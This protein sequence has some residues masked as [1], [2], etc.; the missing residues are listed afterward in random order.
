MWE[1]AMHG[2]AGQR[3]ML[4]QGASA[5]NPIEVSERADVDELQSLYRLT[6][7]LYRARSTDEVFAA[8]LD[9]ITETLGCS[10]ASILLFD[11]D[12]V[13]RFKAARGL[14]ERY[15]TRLEGHT[16]WR[17]G[18]TDPSPIFVEDIDETAEADWVKR[19]IRSEG[20]RSLGFIPLTVD[21]GVVGK[22]MTYYP[23]R[24]TLSQH[25]ADLAVTIARQVGFSVHRARIEAMRR[26][27]EEELRHSEARFRSMSEDAPVM[28]WMSDA[29]GSCLHLNRMLRET[30]GVQED[31]VP[32]FDWRRTM[33]PQD[34]PAIIAAVSD[35]I[36]TRSNL[37]VKG[38]YRRWD[39]A[40]RTFTT[41]ARPNFSAGGQFLGMI[42]VNVD[43]TDQE[44]AAAQRELVF[45][46]L[47]HR[48]KN[49]LALVQAI[50]HQTLKGA[51]AAPLAR[52]FEDRLANLAVAHDLL[53]RTNWENAPLR[54]LL[55]DAL[56]AHDQAL[57][58]ELSGPEVSLAPKQA[59][60]IA[61]AIHELITNAVKYGALSADGGRV[62]LT[63]RVTPERVLDIGWRE[64]GGPAVVA[65][66]RR[67]F[68]SFMIESVLARD[69]DGEVSLDFRPDGLVC[70]IR[71]PLQRA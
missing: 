41:T 60:A 1:S 13:M 61:M 8:G 11:D 62:A 30:W 70:T 48:V 42:G 38:R 7:R 19:E 66:A 34:M 10:R 18:E 15:R 37:S 40:Y 44:E 21:G 17:R 35:A 36:T 23:E 65:P 55:A 63:W 39:G 24:R 6:D 26:L 25:E 46:E 56:S 67:G 51:A 3:R 12:G 54:Q 43:I 71:A 47:N 5:V 59:L 20:I 64:S 32:D 31:A 29:N 4:V 68:G 9:A 58:F 16:P 50:A 27:A 53:T 28:I 2:R 49:T 69:L 52:A 22:F 14:S 33:H 57:R 45:N